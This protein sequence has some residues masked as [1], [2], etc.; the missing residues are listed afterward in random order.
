MQP[1]SLSVQPLL[2]LVVSGLIPELIGIKQN[3]VVYATW[4]LIKNN[5]TELKM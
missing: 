4:N 5:I 3:V 1:I 2:K